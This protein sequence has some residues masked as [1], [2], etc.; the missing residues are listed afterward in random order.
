[1]VNIIDGTTDNDSLTGTA[2]SDSM[3]GLDGADTLRGGDGDD[4]IDGGAGNDRMYGGLGDDTYVVRDAG[5]RVTEVADGGNDTVETW[6]SYQ[7]QDFMENIMLKGADNLSAYGNSLG[8]GIT[9]N[10]GN[11]VINGR[12]G[13]DTID[14][15]GGQDKLDG[16]EGNDSLY[17]GEGDD[18]LSGGN[19]NDTLE[20]DEGADKLNG[21]AGA[22]VLDGGNGNDILDGSTGDDTMGGGDGND[23]YVVDS[24]GD[25]VIEGPADGTDTVK[26]GRDYTLADNV[27][28]L[29]QTGAAHISGAGNNGDNALH[30]NIGNNHLSGGEGNDSLFGGGGDDTLSGGEGDDWL[31]G[32]AGADDFVYDAAGANGYDII[33]GFEHGIDRLV[34]SGADYGF[35]A[36]HALTA[37]EFT[38]GWTAVGTSAQFVLSSGGYLSFDADGSG[39]GAMIQLGRIYGTVTAEDLVFV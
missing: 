34:F 29:H 28:I 10:S 12:D 19:G 2:G 38:L 23:T 35:A 21:G 32:G 4:L 5:D 7:A 17:G 39:A 9:G 31:V 26:T 1:M 15:G 25:F 24:L 14:G 20:G 13:N 6:V 16:A 27:E 37:A 18:S 33:N 11:N 22:D 3:N 30:G 36:G 8:N